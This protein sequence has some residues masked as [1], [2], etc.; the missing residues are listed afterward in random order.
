MVSSDLSVGKKDS[1]IELDNLNAPLL[2][3]AREGDVSIKASLRFIM[4]GLSFML[5]QFLRSFMCLVLTI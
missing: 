1:W 5:S 3:H 2:D 4:N